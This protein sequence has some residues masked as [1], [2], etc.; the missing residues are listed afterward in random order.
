MICTQSTVWYPIYYLVSHPPP[1]T[2]P[3]SDTPSTTWY[4]IID[5]EYSLGQDLWLP[6]L[7]PAPVHLP[8]NLVS[9]PIPSDPTHPV[10][11]LEPHSHLSHPNLAP[12]VSAPNLVPAPI[13][14]DTPQAPSWDV[15]FIV[16]FNLTSSRFNLTLQVPLHTKIIFFTMHGKNPKNNSEA[17]PFTAIRYLYKSPYM[18]KL[19][20]PPL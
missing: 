9:A 19:Q 12:S 4:P 5:R 8:P 17:T 10:P 7:A 1:S 15:H 13:W 16:C 11:D 6:N 20:I 2:P 14:S 18:P 3:L